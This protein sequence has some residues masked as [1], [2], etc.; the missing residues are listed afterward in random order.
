[1]ETV[2]KS[3]FVGYAGV[4]DGERRWEETIANDLVR[5]RSRRCQCDSEHD[6]GP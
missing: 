4:V 6:Q 5:A 2:G 1:M 3:Q